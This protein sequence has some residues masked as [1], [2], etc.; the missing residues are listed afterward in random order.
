MLLAAALVASTFQDLQ[1]VQVTPPSFGMARE[2]Q[3]A[4]DGR[5]TYIAYGM[6]DTTYI[7]ISTDHGKTF[8]TPIK[9]GEPGKL[10]L[11]MRRGPRIA[12]HE[13]VI[14]VTAT[15]G[16]LGGGRDGDLI[17]FRSEDEGRTWSAVE[18][19]GV[20]GSAREGLHGMAVASDG[21][22]ACAWLDL[23]TKSTQ[24]YMSSSKDGGATW[25]E[26]QLVYASP[27]GAICECCH[28]SLAFD[29]KGNLYVMFRN[30]LDGSRDMYTTFSQDL[31]TFSPALKLGKGTWPLRAC[32][33]DGGM[34]AAGPKG[35]L[36]TIWRREDTIYTARLAQPEKSQAK[37]AQPWIAINQAGTYIAWQNGR[38]IM[39]VKPYSSVLRVS[40]RGDSPVVAA[41]GDMAIGAWTE[42]GIKAVSF[43]QAR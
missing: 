18:V 35:D 33:M 21:T 27:S 3:V 25:S 4:L 29:G 41:S 38:E 12:V 36:Q 15:Y 40:E 20:E 28:P 8:G 10:S 43:S 5:R 19:N 32:P 14:T 23:R 7:S 13:G 31:R 1:V 37:G 11:G 2:P 30:S 16:P 17:A 26:N 22:L 34:L 6:G 24:L 9:V 39:F 42:K